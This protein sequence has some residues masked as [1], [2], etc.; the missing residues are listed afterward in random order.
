HLS[1]FIGINVDILS[2][3]FQCSFSS[4]QELIILVINLKV[5]NIFEKHLISHKKRPI[6]QMWL[7]GNVLL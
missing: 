7:P 5:N 6:G 4:T 3:S 2:F 1:Y